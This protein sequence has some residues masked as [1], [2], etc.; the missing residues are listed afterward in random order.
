MAADPGLRLVDEIVKSSQ[1]REP[2]PGLSIF[3][4]SY[5]RSIFSHARQVLVSF[6]RHGMQSFSPRV[7]RNKGLKPASKIHSF[8]TILTIVTFLD[9]QNYA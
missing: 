3:Q 7:I 9:D 2:K 4:I 1:N 5:A 8:T 6:S